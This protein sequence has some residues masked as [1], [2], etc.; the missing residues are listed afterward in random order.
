MDYNV[1]EAIELNKTNKQQETTSYHN[2]L[3]Q[4]KNDDKGQ[5]A[6]TRQNN[7]QTANKQN[8]RTNEQTTLIFFLDHLPRY[9]III[10][11]TTY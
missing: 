11:T 3:V 9:I 10:T 1:L 8:E 5:S 6:Q 7:K 4:T 2:I